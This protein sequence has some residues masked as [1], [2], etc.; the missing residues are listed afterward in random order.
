MESIGSYDGFTGKTWRWSLD[1]DACCDVRS[2][3]VC[4]I[5]E[6][7]GL[8]AKLMDFYSTSDNAAGD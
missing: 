3:S 8:S 5:V 7:I 6:M 1:V 4:L 2:V